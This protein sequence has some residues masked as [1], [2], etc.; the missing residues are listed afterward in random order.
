[1]NPKT[2]PEEAHKDLESR[3]DASDISST[4]EKGLDALRGGAV[5][6]LDTACRLLSDVLLFAKNALER[7][8]LLY[9][10]RNPEILGT[11]EDHHGQWT[12]PPNTYSGGIHSRPIEP[13]MDDEWG[14]PQVPMASP[15]SPRVYIGKS[16]FVA[17]LVHLI[18]RVVHAGR[19]IERFVADLFNQPE[20]PVNQRAAQSFVETLFSDAAFATTTKQLSTALES[21]A[22]RGIPYRSLQRALNRAASAARQGTTRSRSKKPRRN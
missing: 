7:P 14:M 5:L 17:S 6:P 18:E 3:A 16:A 9:A 21:R 8:T 11:D 12:V 19:E 13:K 2:T 22:R 20:K 4:I 10:E 15:R 1:M